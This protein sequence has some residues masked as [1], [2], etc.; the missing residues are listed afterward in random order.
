M[1]LQEMVDE[2]VKALR[3]K[4]G[5]RSVRLVEAVEIEISKWEPGMSTAEALN[6][7]DADPNSLVDAVTALT[8][9][10]VYKGISIK[11]MVIGK[12]KHLERLHILLV[13]GVDD[14]GK[15]I[16]SVYEELTQ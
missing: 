16:K 14:E 4:E 1:K 2:H 13:V 6:A 8:E 7:K 15:P 12:G 9:H 10:G 11:F 5:C 3:D